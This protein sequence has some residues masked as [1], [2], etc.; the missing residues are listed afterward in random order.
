M[1]EF[2]SWRN[3]SITL[4]DLARATPRRMEG[5]AARSDPSMRIM[6]GPEPL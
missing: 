2:V 4:I 6:G 3:I 1:R 5:T